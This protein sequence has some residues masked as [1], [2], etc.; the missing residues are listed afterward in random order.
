MKRQL[1]SI[2]MRIVPVLLMICIM[3]LAALYLY[4][5]VITA[6]K[7]HSW[8]QLSNAT[9]TMA[10]KVDIRFSDNLNLL[11]RV[12]DA[13]AYQ[14]DE[15]EM[16]KSDQETRMLVYLTAVME[17]TIFSR[18]DVLYPDRIL[19]M[20]GE[21][22]PIGDRMPFEDVW[23][24]GNH[25]SN[26]HTD[27][28]LGKEVVYCG[29]PIG[30][31]GEKEGVLIGVIDCKAMETMFQSQYYG[32]A[33]EIF[34]IDCNDGDYIMDTWHKELG[35]LIDL[36]DRIPLKGYEEVDFRQE[37]MDGKTGKVGFIS[38]TTGKPAYMYYTRAKSFNWSVVLMV[39]ESL[40]LENALLLKEMLIWVGVFSACLFLLFAGWNVYLVLVA[41]KNETKA[42]ATELERATN[43]AKSR[44]LS[45]ISHDIR[46][47][48][49][50]IVGMVDVIDRHV[51]DPAR[52]QESLRKIKVSARYLTTLVN[53][54][55]EMNEIERGKI[56]LT[57][58]HINLPRLASDLEVLIAPKAKEKGIEYTIDCSALK[59]P[60]VLGS[61]S[62]I[63]RILV[64]LVTNA[65]KYNKKDGKVWVT[66]KEVT[67]ENDEGMYAFIVKDTGVGMSEEFQKNMFDAFEQENVGARTERRGYGLG[68][69]I[70]HRLV[71]KMDGCIEVKSEEGEGS[72]FTV[73]LPLRYGK[74]Q[75]RRAS[76]AGG[77][78]LSGI[79]ILLAEDNELNMEIARVLLTDVG[80]DV[81]PVE[82]GRLAVEA[83]EA[84]APETI[85]V[86]LMDIMMPEMDGLEA[87]RAIRALRRDDAMTVPIIAMTANAF[88]QDMARCL[89]AGMDE[90]VAKPL[91]MKALIVLIA[92]LV[93]ERR[94]ITK[95]KDR[96]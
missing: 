46:T 59:H 58:E 27:S 14:N 96:G 34:I 82:N 51:D 88:A 73:L 6:E 85:D 5:K 44:F 69:S 74:T 65:I 3:S 29:A 60:D 71:E 33:A 72:V 48:L 18:I 92:G 22:I 38:K 45:S 28:V 54:V 75:P 56:I 9:Q 91:D 64:N 76:S 57:S 39:E 7:A 37:M 43:E 77:S 68:L 95:L 80:A 15:T 49:N 52:V 12:A 47:P 67:E 30:I 25:I 93:E 55:L 1:K 78:D 16:E 4:N 26:R 84:S 53:D 83:F 50:G 24:L 19:L 87:T 23:D 86:V 41:A 81:V 11:G 94:T 2:V 20:S 62:H 8:D 40:V 70:V 13:I 32:E 61:P 31:Q 36:G 66:I 63:H 42:R 35:N 79:R 10:E 21:S 90:H 17:Q 89:D